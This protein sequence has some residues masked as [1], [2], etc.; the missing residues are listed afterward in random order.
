MAADPVHQKA[1][2]DAWDRIAA[3][4]DSLAGFERDYYLL[5]R[6]DAFGCELFDIARH[7]VRLTAERPKPNAD[8]LREYRDSALES[9]EFQLFSPAPIPSRTGA[10]RSFQRA[11]S[12]FAEN[13]GGEHPLV[14]KALATV[15]VT[16]RARYAELVNG[17]K[18]IDPAER[19]RIAAGGPQAVEES[20][21][22]MLQFARLMDPDARAVR[23][24]F[25]DEVEEVERQ[26]NARI[27][28]AG[29]ELLGTAKAPDATFT[30]RLAFGVVKG[31][32]VDGV[33]CPFSTTFGAVR[34]SGRSGKATAS[35]SSCRS[36][37]RT[38]RADS[39]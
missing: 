15:Q 27:A 21:D 3:A 32:S 7:L 33:G 25:E 4:E 36:A 24:R 20:A 37:G 16:R 18:L 28:K 35:R 38:P 31:Y 13:L 5:E 12:F 30:L 39:T 26:A 23:K 11:L 34:S 14:L 17:T 8:R 10:C 9:L 22:A 29:F 2:G 19:R 1:Y 6:G